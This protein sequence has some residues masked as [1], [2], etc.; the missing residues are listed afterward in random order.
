MLKKMLYSMSGT[1]SKVTINVRDPVHTSSPTVPNTLGEDSYMMQQRYDV[2]HSSTAAAKTRGGA[3]S[4][5]VISVSSSPS[6]SP[7]IEVA[8]IEDMDDDPGTTRWRTLGDGTQLQN[9]LIQHFPYFNPGRSP[10]RAIDAIAIGF[11]RGKLHIL[12]P[13][14]MNLMLTYPKTPLLLRTGHLSC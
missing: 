2:S 1:P 5:N 6:R 10:H 3:S 11:E 4:P 14:S 13:C 9:T 12:Y 8:E 7:E